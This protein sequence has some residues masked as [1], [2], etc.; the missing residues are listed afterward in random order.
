ML[1]NGGWATSG[2]V[3]GVCCFMSEGQCALVCF[4]KQ[5]KVEIYL[6]LF[7]YLGD[8]YFTFW[9]N[10]ANFKSFGY[11]QFA[12]KLTLLPIKLLQ[13]TS[14]GDFPHSFTNKFTEAQRS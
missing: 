9:A 13:C 12:Q 1:I 4:L 11:L 10:Q 7:T 8:D 5:N 3:E 6:N 14:W 2:K